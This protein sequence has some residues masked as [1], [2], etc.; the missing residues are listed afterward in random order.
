MY[1]EK[2]VKAGYAG[3]KKILVAAR[4]DAALE[5]VG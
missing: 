4:A 5:V 1:L 3:R 2:R